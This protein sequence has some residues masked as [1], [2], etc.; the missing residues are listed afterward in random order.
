MG[1]EV[2]GMEVRSEGQLSLANPSWVDTMST[3]QTAVTP[4]GWGVKADMIRV[5]V[6]GK[7]V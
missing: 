1:K 7:T 5:C 4:C 6:A 2:P 3:S